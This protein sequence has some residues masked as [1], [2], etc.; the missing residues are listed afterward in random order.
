[1]DPAIPAPLV[2]P[3]SDRDLIVHYLRNKIDNMQLPSD[4]I[5]E[6]DFYSFDPDEL[7][8]RSITFF[9]FAYCC[10]CKGIKT[11]FFVLSV[12]YNP[13]NRPEAFYFTR[14]QILRGLPRR[15]VRNVGYWKSVGP[16]HSIPPD[17]DP[18]V[19]Y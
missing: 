2:F 15:I 4:D 14:R 16:D 3:P 9:F 19:G 13:L 6:L 11:F 8:G 18:K 17:E 5:I 10:F 1:M 12:R 7:T